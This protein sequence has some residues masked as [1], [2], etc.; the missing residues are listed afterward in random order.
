VYSTVQRG[1]VRAYSI[2]QYGTGDTVRY[3]L[4]IR[5]CVTRVR[6]VYRTVQRGSVR[7]YSIV[8][9]GTGDSNYGYLGSRILGNWVIDTG[10]R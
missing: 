5:T 3:D 10:N 9:Y 7:A 2:V 8:Q 4:Y 1:S 6:A